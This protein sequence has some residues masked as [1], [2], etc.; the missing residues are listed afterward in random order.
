MQHSSVPSI[1]YID[2]RISYSVFF[3]DWIQMWSMI[4]FFRWLWGSFVDASFPGSLLTTFIAASISPLLWMAGLFALAWSLW[5]QDND[6]S[7]HW[8]PIC[9]HVNPGIHTWSNWS[10]VVSTQWNLFHGQIKYCHAVKTLDFFPNCWEKIC[11]HI[12]QSLHRK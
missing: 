11:Y 6:P 2:H 7:L 4:A 3:C 10:K 12:V 9:S 1:V 8:P 5:K